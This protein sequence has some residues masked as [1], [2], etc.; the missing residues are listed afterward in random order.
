MSDRQRLIAALTA[1]RPPRRPANPPRQS[2]LAFRLATQPGF[3]DWMLSWLHDDTAVFADGAVPNPLLALNAEDPDGFVYAL[4]SAWAAVGD[5]LAFYQ[6]RILNEGFLRTATEEYSV[7]ELVATVGYSPRPALS[8]T[9]HLAFTLL[10]AR[11]AVERLAIPKG[12]AV[13]SIPAPGETAVIFE[14]G[15][16]IEARPAWNALSLSLPRAK[17]WPQLAPGATRARVTGGQVAANSAIVFLDRGPGGPAPAA[18]LVA[19]ARPEPP[20]GTTL[21]EWSPALDLPAGAE[22]PPALQLC[23][24]RARL[25]G[26]GAPPWDRQPDAI[27]ALHG[28]RLGRVAISVDGGANWSPRAAG[29]PPDDVRA[30]AF[31]EAGGLHAAVADGVFKQAPD[32]AWALLAKPAL[33][34][35]ILC[36]AAGGRD[37]LFAGTQRGEV[38]CSQDGGLTWYGLMGALGVPP[39]A[40]KATRLPVTPVQAVTLAR[41][42]AGEASLVAGTAAGVWTAPAHGGF[43]TPW[44]GGLPGFNPTDRTA[45]V[46]IR[47]LARDP[48]SRRIVAATDRGLFFANAVGDRWSQ[49]VVT[50]ATA[51]GVGAP[52]PKPAAM[53]AFDLSADRG[54][55]LLAA[56][57]A[58][59]VCS[60]DG[61]RRW[62]VLAAPAGAAATKVASVNGRL[63]AG[64][65]K[66]LLVSDDRGAALEAAPPP[67]TGGRITALASSAGT[68]AVSEAFTG[69]LETEW[70][71]LRLGRSAEPLAIDLDRIYATL[72]AGSWMALTGVRPAEAPETA[73]TPFAIALPVIGVS[74]VSR[75]DFA[76][77]G[78]VTRVLTDGLPFEIDPRTTTAHIL[79]R[80]LELVEIRD[81]GSHVLLGD[82]MVSQPGEAAAAIAL[83]GAIDDLTDR[84]VAISGRRARL[85]IVGQAGG[86]RRW[87][88]QAQAWRP[89]GSGNFDT[90][91]LLASP[92]H[93]LLMGAEDGVRQL[94][95]G[96]WRLWPGGSLG[97][98]CYGLAEAPDGGIVAGTDAGVWRGSA[99][100]GWRPLGLTGRV[101]AVSADGEA[102]VA[103]TETGL[104]QSLDGGATWIACAPAAGAA[105]VALAR[106]G[107]GGLVAAAADGRLFLNAG[108]GWRLSPTRPDAPD[109][110]A[111]AAR[112]QTVFAGSSIGLFQSDDAGKTWAR[113]AAPE[114][115]CDVRAVVADA[116]GSVWWAVRGRGV[117]QDD[118]LHPTGV[119]NDV[120]ALAIDGQGVL[121]AGSRVSAALL[122]VT[123]P[124]GADLGEPSY[125]QTATGDI[126]DA[127][128][129]EGP[130]SADLRHYFD[131]YGLAP[132]PGAGIARLGG[133]ALTGAAWRIG[134]E[135]AGGF[136]VFDLGEGQYG[137]VTEAG[138]SIAAPPIAVPGQVSRW[139]LLTP[140]GVRVSL[141]ALPGEVGFRAAEAGAELAADVAVISQSAVQDDRSSTEITLR[142]PLGNVYDAASVTVNANVAPASHGET[143]TLLEVVG[144]GDA[145]V[146]SQTFPLRRKPL[147]ALRT[148]E[149]PGYRFE[150]EVRVRTSSPYSAMALSAQSRPQAAEDSSV[151]WTQVADLGRSKPTDSHFMVQQLD[152]GGAALVFGDGVYG[153]RLPSGQENVLALYRTG[154]GE[155]GNVAADRLTL[156]LRRPPG[157]KKVT[158]PVPATGGLDAEQLVEGR[159]IGPI[160]IRALGRVIS[161]RDLETFVRAQQGVA[162]VRLDELMRGG[163]PLLHFSIASVDDAAAAT[164]AGVG[165]AQA[166]D[167]RTLQRSFDA[168]GVQARAIAFSAYTPRGF[169]LAARV[170]IAPG[171]DEA[172]VLAA[173]RAALAEAFGFQ[174]RGLAAAVHAAEL[175][176]CLQA[177]AGVEGVVLDEL[178]RADQR[179]ERADVLPASAAIAGPPTIGAEL[180]LIKDISVEPLSTAGGGVG[181]QPL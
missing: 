172:A 100:D 13:K 158:N 109:I 78:Q 61:G 126:S 76:T 63:L 42:E 54:G 117:M 6:E 170:A 179:P 23:G 143:S 59:L 8:A 108:G 75:R 40:G 49:A 169:N 39:P 147:T 89:A 62:R 27:K 16:D 74:S 7:R 97:R 68:I 84:T 164:G 51:A 77:S 177:V 3:R 151:A 14:T 181:A 127:L 64:G 119:A 140:S 12:T 118:A 166:A 167:L 86:V 168:A 28:T 46:S 71:G 105:I 149:D 91:C 103:G 31:D 135:A 133:G 56:T 50:A 160:G 5:N 18:R 154:G 113:R 34:A 66:G 171:F 22:E 87:D 35:R 9:T 2:E 41:G 129:Q 131:Q 10:E 152:G 80:P 29:L 20:A 65:D 121:H 48:A 33:G 122:P 114:G 52:S 67:L 136:T 148:L 175:V 96:V 125:L 45:A 92:G 44:N 144:S 32:G 69:F 101:D 173:A 95:D 134:D 21:V 156:A 83:A 142:P 155:G 124:A 137:V 120:R 153:R 98:P 26:A 162:K 85:R 132:P 19:G 107:S 70:P 38:W 88:A 161:R 94:I 145:S 24:Q 79:S 174:N 104:Y 72:A 165:V 15:E 55:A 115:P 150:V 25:F 128:N 111:L 106:T 53:E 37:Q 180:L 123:G 178:Y 90:H 146:A 4:I 130:V 30:L 11:G 60:T 102:I 163:R 116:K 110:A 112:G 93:G 57:A 1:A 17:L 176:S 73:P 58:G 99:A 82:G 81:N 141:D 47:A 139:T 43:W 138:L 159:E 36:L 157:V